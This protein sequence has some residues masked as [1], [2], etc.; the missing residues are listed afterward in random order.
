[1]IEAYAVGISLVV[2]SNATTAVAGFRE[3]FEAIDRIVVHT[4]G[5]VKELATGL[6]G[7]R[8]VGQEAAAA[9]QAAAMAME[10]AAVAAQRAAVRGIPGPFGP[11]GGG[12]GAPGGAA[13]WGLNMPVAVGGP[14]PATGGFLLSGAPY[15][16]AGG[17]GV[18]VGAPYFGAMAPYRQGG[19]VI[20][21]NTRRPYDDPGTTA[22][23]PGHVPDQIPLGNPGAGGMPTGVAG[24]GTTLLGWWDSV[25]GVV[26]AYLAMRALRSGVGAEFDVA[27]EQLRL[28][29]MGF[30]DAQ[31]RQAFAAA[32]RA[33][34]NIPPSTIG[35]NLDIVRDL[36]AILQNPAS[37]IAAMP[38]F[39]AL[40][41]VLQ[42]YGKSEEGT[43]LFAAMRSGELRGVLTTR[44]AVTGQ[45]VISPERLAKFVREVQATTVI[46][47]GKIGP[48]ELFSF[49]RRGGVSAQMIDDP[50]LFADQ[51]SNII[52]FGASQAGTALQ[53]F[54]M[55]FSAGKMSQAAI[56][57]LIAIGEISDPSK[58]GKLPMGNALLSPNAMPPGDLAMARQR[59]AEFIETVLLPRMR[60]FLLGKSGVDIDT[61]PL[62]GDAKMQASLRGV[63]KNFDPGFA[64]ETPEQQLQTEASLGQTLAS[65]IPGGREI[66]EALFNYAL[67]QRDRAA[68]SRQLGA[69][70]VYSLFKEQS[71]GVQLGGLGAAWQGFE[72]AV[73]RLAEPAMSDAM[74]A[75]TSVLNALANA[76]NF[77]GAGRLT[78]IPGDLLDPLGLDGG[79][80]DPAPV[81]LGAP[82]APGLVGLIWRLASGVAQAQPLPIVDGA[83]QVRVIN[84]ADLARGV[85]EH[86]AREADTPAAGD[87]S[88]DLRG[89]PYGALGGMP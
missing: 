17:A 49:I 9:W 22:I 6:G 2:E 61:V 11:G 48:A 47:G 45:D 43:A 78:P 72:V 81:V 20:D 36:M 28:K 23:V 66:A 76:V 7:L 80:R 85:G 87:W 15:G 55:Q 8:T 44:D 32:V 1:M 35:A 71:P 42:R 65:R 79:G 69:P 37:S 56:D 40:G 30:T 57:I 4:Q 29:G 24:L 26:K 52:A 86:L 21:P 75:Y 51:M 38:E 14:M 83:I 62:F 74:L 63:L 19:G 34:Q 5:V 58:L 77:V 13:G 73:L 68:F 50:S 12:G 70:D 33:Q 89:S 16:P 18:P 84:P 88:P 67:K 25:P 39:S 41:A 46:S 60:A 54:G 3:Q 53:G 64:A 59:P 10:R 82:G 27:D 31:A